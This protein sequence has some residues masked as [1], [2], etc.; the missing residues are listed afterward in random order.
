MLQHKASDAA[1]LITVIAPTQRTESPRLIWRALRLDNDAL[2]R[3]G[4]AVE[5][6]KLQAG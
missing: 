3:H 5:V 6:Q 2:D 4:I 1:Q